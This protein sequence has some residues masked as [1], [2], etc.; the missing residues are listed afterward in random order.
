M[1]HLEE[2]GDE[3]GLYGVTLTGL[4][5]VLPHLLKDIMNR[6]WITALVSDIAIQSVFVPGIKN[7]EGLL[8]TVACLKH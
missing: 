4:K 8:I 5:K 3:L 2:I 6:C 7:I 1:G